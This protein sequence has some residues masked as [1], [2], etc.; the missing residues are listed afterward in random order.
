MLTV[1]TFVAVTSWAARPFRGH[2]SE[3]VPGKPPESD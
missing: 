2:R 3:R 1:T